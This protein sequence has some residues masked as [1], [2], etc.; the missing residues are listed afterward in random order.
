M[1]GLI[2]FFIESSLTSGVSIVGA[3]PHERRD[4]FLCFLRKD[5]A[6]GQFVVPRNCRASVSDPTRSE[7]FHRNALQKFSSLSDNRIGC[8]F[9]R[10][11]DNQ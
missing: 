9:W 1:F 5:V 7:A 10:V 8:A 4:F 11:M 6:F 2:C 3:R